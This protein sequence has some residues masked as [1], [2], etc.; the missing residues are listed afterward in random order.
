MDYEH[1]EMNSA[2]LYIIEFSKGLLRIKGSGDGEGNQRGK[3]EKIV[4]KAFYGQRYPMPL[5]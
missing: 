4:A 5:C 1:G 2:G 3:K